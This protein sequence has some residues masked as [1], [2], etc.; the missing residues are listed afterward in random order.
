MGEI[1]YFPPPITELTLQNDE[2][3]AKALKRVI[4]FL[5]LW[6]QLNSRDLTIIPVL[7]KG[8]KALLSWQPCFEQKC[9]DWGL[10]T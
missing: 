10:M 5:N 9:H 8:S 1:G 2:H 4:S 7:Y 3:V 6:G